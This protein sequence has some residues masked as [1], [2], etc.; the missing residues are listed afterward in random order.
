MVVQVDALRRAVAAITPP[1]GKEASKGILFS[2]NKD[3]TTLILSARWPE[4]QSSTNIPIEATSGTW[5][6]IGFNAKYLLSTIN[7]LGGP[8]VR[9]L[10]NDNSGPSIWRQAEDDQAMAVTMPMRF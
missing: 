6:D 5:V 10:W 9:L 8:A 3:H 7:M 2:C 1:G 4:G